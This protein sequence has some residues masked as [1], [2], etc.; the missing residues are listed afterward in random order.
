MFNGL[1]IILRIRL[2]GLEFRYVE[3]RQQVGINEEIFKWY[4]L[5]WIDKICIYK[6]KVKL[7]LNMCNLLEE[8]E[9]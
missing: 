4:K 1:E 7:F 8:S 6:F 3:I 2:Y 9:I 5:F